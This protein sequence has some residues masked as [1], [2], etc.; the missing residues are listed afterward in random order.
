[1]NFE[2][3]LI[4]ILDAM[5]STNLRP[6]QPLDNADI[7]SKPHYRQ[8]I[9]FSATMPTAVETLA[10]NYL[11]QPIFITVGERHG[12][13]NANVE[14]RIEWCTTEGQKRQKLITLLAARNFPMIIFCNYKKSC[15]GVLRICEDEGVSAVVLHGGKAQDQREAA[16]ASLKNGSIQVII[17]TDVMGRGIDISNLQH[18]VNYELPDSIDKYLHRIGRTGRAG[19]KGIAS[20]LM[21]EQDTAIMYDL[22]ELLTA[23]NAYIPPQLAHN[24]NANAKPGTIVE[25]QKSKPKG[26]S[27]SSFRKDDK[28]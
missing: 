16:L 28:W 20:S 24:P 2:P 13:A 8:T 3:Q 10:K 12:Q 19:K 1:M 7:K 18:V 27:S 21:T 26:T 15:D 14:Q 25:R 17:A 6:E 4:K 23:V 9:M 22:K 11:R 5:P